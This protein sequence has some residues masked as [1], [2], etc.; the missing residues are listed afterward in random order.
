M[1][2]NK[3]LID[4]L[5]DGVD[6]PD[7]AADGAEVEQEGA[8]VPSDESIIAALEKPSEAVQA[9]L[10]KIVNEAVKKALARNTPKRT[11]VKA[12]P[13]TKEQFASMSYAERENLY[14]TNRPL[15][16]KLKNS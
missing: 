12:D 3:T 11:T 4:A 5:A 6:I 8:E 14:N 2:E 15:Y 7:D 9:A 16:E 10:Q 13:I 1:D